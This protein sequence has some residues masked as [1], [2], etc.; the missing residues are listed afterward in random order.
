[1]GCCESKNPPAHDIPKK[2]SLKPAPEVERI[3]GPKPTQLDT[4][5]IKVSDPPKEEPKPE[6]EI[7]A[8]EPEQPKPEPVMASIDSELEARL[9]ELEASLS[10]I[11]NEV[12]EKRKEIDEHT[13]YANEINSMLESLAENFKPIFDDLKSTREAYKTEADIPNSNSDEIDD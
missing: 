5:E 6:P 11:N 7:K 9:A 13:N 4:Q 8:P 10:Q 2:P 1:M 12:E 3:L